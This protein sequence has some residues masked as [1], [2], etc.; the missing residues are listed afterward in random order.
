MQDVLWRRLEG[1]IVVLD[2]LRAEDVDAL[3]EAG[4]DERIWA[5]FPVTPG[6]EDSFRRYHAGLLAEAEAGGYA[7]FVTRDA[8]T[9][10]PLGST[11]FLTIRP[12]HRGVEIGSTWLTPAA[13]GSGANVEAK[14]L[15]LRHAF[16][17][18]GCMRVEWKTDARNER[19]CRALEALGATPEGVHRKH[20]LRHYGIRDSAWFSVVDDEWPVVK[21]LL[22]A[23]IAANLATR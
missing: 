20:M 19:S 10:E 21:E 23:R 14:Y 5:W 8:V 6:D 18:A 17:E 22:E 3:W 13:W 12:E 4:R 15:M 16:E 1:R 9:G 2:P 7:P 11:S